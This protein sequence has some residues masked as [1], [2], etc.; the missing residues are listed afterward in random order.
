MRPPAALFALLLVALLLAAPVRAA[1]D[2]PMATP[3]WTAGDFWVYRFNTTFENAVFLNGT[4]RAEVL[5]LENVTVRGVPTDAYLVDTEGN[6]T[7]DGSFA[8]GT[9][10]LRA[11]GSWNLTGEERF[12]ATSRVVVTSLLDIT[13]QGHVD[14]L[15][16]PF[17]LHWI[18]STESRIVRDTWTYPVPL[19]TSGEIVLNDSWSEDVFVRLDLNDTATNRTG[20]TESTLGLSLAE[21]TQSVTVPAGAFEA[22]VVNQT[23]SDGSRER[24]DYAPQ[25][26]NNARTITYNGTGE[27]V[28]RTELLSYRYQALE[29]KAGFP[30][31]IVVAVVAAVAV[32]LLGAWALRRRRIREKAYTPPSL[33]DPP[34]T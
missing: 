26:G 2:A 25:V 19:G 22:F 1:P 24:F 3:A 10:S 11:R 14:V 17:T 6:G 12:T 32:V 18:N 27:E 9:F 23:A 16:A 34:P 4:V 28:G 21:R 20:L 29:P 31:S 30:L 33:R 8:A 13:G 5:A 7:L 15:N